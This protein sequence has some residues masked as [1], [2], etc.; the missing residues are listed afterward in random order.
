MKNGSKKTGSSTRSK[1]PGM[2]KVGDTVVVIAGGNQ[3]KRPIKGQVGK[4]KA[5]VGEEQDRVVVEGLN[6]FVKHQKQAGPD[7]P[8][9]KIKLEKSMHISNVR[10]YVEKDKKAVRLCKQV[11]KDGEKIRGYRDSKTK[12]FVALEA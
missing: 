3:K 5:F 6:L 10:Y 4:I 9:G 1:R 11:G 2:L 8:A 12:K 7:K